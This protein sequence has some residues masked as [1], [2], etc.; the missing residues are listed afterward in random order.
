M[1]HRI[2]D[3]LPELL[4][5]AK[6]PPH[7][8]YEGQPSSKN[9]SFDYYKWTQTK[10]FQEAINLATYGWPKGLKAVYKL[11][12][13]YKEVFQDLLP[14][15]DHATEQTYD[16]EG[17]FVDI[18][19]YIQGDPECMVKFIPSNDKVKQGNKLQRIVV[20]GSFSSMINPESLF[21]HSALIINL[22]DAIEMCGFK[23]EI[24]MINLLANEYC[25]SALLVYQT[26]LKQFEDFPDFTKIAFCLCH[27][28][29]FRRIILSLMEQE[30][31]DTRRNLYITP[32]GFYGYPVQI[33]SQLLTTNDLH[34]P[35]LTSNISNI[36]Q[37]IQEFK[38][39]IQQHFGEQV[40]TE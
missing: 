26:T 38:Q 34:I 4:E 7:P 30:D 5:A 25:G 1:I 2:Y 29:M 12:S 33:P 3:S 13:K 40:I 10:N 8:E 32:D 23:T 31:N 6:L 28:S 16:I 35:Q 36:D 37:K 27:P 39:I 14:K 15:Q 17:E 22:S 19:R 21:I 11:A 18:G 9:T 20:N 24:V